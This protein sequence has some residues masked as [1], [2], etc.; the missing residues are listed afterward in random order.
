VRGAKAA[1]AFV[2]DSRF[3]ARGAKARS[4]EALIQWTWG[5]ALFQSAEYDA[6][7]EHLR[8]TATLALAAGMRFVETDAMRDLG[9]ISYRRGEIQEARTIYELC[10]KTA[11]EADDRRGESLALDLLSNSI[12]YNG[13]F[14]EGLKCAERALDLAEETG[15]RRAQCI[16]VNTLGE[17]ARWTGDLKTALRHY[18]KAAELARD[19]GEKEFEG[20]ALANLAL[21]LHNLGK[22]RQAEAEARRAIAVL[23]AIGVWN[24][25]CATTTVLGHVRLALGDHAEASEAYSLAHSK[26]RELG[27]A[28]AAMESAAGLAAVELAKGRPRNALER[29][30]PILD[31]VWAADAEDKATGCPPRHHLEGA[32]E[33][34]RV[35]HTC[36]QVLDACK[37]P[38]ALR[39]LTR[40]WEVLSAQAKMLPAGRAR[41]AFFN[42]IPSHRGIHEA[43]KEACKEKSKV[44]SRLGS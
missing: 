12:F 38:R 42:A 22:N 27:E 2:A 35:Y 39:I 20:I 16:I 43:W 7:R 1:A 3:S 5:H 37:D 44:T 24:R 34:F 15:D 26:A 41:R 17:Q 23:K 28:A 4:I 9:R 21:A 19:V 6:A 31:H 25:V 33:P 32:D 18:E 10:A 8:K 11:R 14:G 30:A 40:A 13:E 36:C 29:I